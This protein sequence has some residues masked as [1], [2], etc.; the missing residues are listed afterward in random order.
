MAAWSR[1]TRANWRSRLIRFWRWVV[2]LRQWPMI[3]IGGGSIFCRRVLPEHRAAAIHLVGSRR[4]VR[5]SRKSARGTN[6]ASHPYVESRVRRLPVL[7][8]TRG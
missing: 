5:V 4:I 6:F 8:E 7:L 2:P 3:K 1:V